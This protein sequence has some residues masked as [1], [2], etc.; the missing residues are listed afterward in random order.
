MFDLASMEPYSFPELHKSISKI[1]KDMV[2]YLPR[3][4]DLRQ[5]ARHA[6]DEEKLAV[7]HYCMRGASK[8]LCVFF[9]SFEGV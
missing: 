5:L 4:S 1:T 3:T 7:K 2:F 9:G 6:Q 8:A